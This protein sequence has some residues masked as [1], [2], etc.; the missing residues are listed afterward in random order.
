MTSSVLFWK[1]RKLKRKNTV[2]ASSKSNVGRGIK[3]HISAL[4]FFTVNVTNTLQMSATGS[5]A[6]SKNDGKMFNARKTKKKNNA[7]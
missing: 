1:S 3:K 2:C 7:L 6:Y 4:L 5:R